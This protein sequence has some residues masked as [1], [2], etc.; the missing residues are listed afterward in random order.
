M[1]GVGACVWLVL[2]SYTQQID[3]PTNKP[4]ATNRQVFNSQAQSGAYHIARLVAA[5]FGALRIELVD[6]SPEDVT[7]LLTG[8]RDIIR[9]DAQPSRLWGVL[10]KVKDSNGRAGGVGG[11]SLDVRGERAAGTLRPTAATLKA[12]AAGGGGAGGR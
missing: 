1:F 9:G 10:N 4:N 11:G 6:E 7:R 2:L 3:R 12:A 8:Y 5:G